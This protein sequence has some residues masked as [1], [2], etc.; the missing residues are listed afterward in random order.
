M[1]RNVILVLLA[2]AF[3]FGLLAWLNQGRLG[4]VVFKN[5]I[6]ASMA[7]DVVQE[8]DS[9]LHVA[10]CGTGS[11]MSDPSRAGP[12]TAVIAGNR[13]YVVDVGEGAAR[14]FG[15][16]GLRLDRTEAVFLTHFHSD[17]INGLGDLLIQRWANSGAGEP[18]AIYGPV[19]TESIVTGYNTILSYDRDY[20]IM[21]HGENM[22]ESGYGGHAVEFALQG[23]KPAVVFEENGLIVTAVQVTHGGIVPAVAYRFDYGGRSVVISGDT[24]QSS[25]LEALAVEADILFHE[26]LQP[27]MIDVMSAEFKSTNR[28]RL[29]QIFQ[30]IK[31]I[32]TTP[33]EAAASADRA[34]VRMLVLTHII[35]PTPSPFLY[36]YYMQGT[37]VMFS[38]RIEMAEDGMLFSLPEGKTR[39]S[40]RELN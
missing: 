39:I 37:S 36:K 13:L 18:L 16:M 25:A 31:A 38:G 1:K 28:A 4:G 6:K 2:V 22:P 7:R 20:R 35:P 15:P 19:G 3:L 24:S 27:D 14:N 12:C 32:H 26:A 29:A 5:R 8:V 30:E 23:D 11:P 40:R 33:V 10:M 34:G 17:H 9:G 21:H